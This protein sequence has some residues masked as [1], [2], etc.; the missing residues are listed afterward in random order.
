MWVGKYPPSA[1]WQR[2]IPEKIVSIPTPKSKES[3]M[4]REAV[5][6]A[7]KAHVYQCDCGLVKDVADG[8][9]SDLRLAL[10]AHTEAAFKEKNRWI[11]RV[12]TKCGY[13]AVDQDTK[14]TFDDLGAQLVAAEGELQ[15]H[16]RSLAELG[17]WECGHVCE[18][19]GDEPDECR[20]CST[21]RER[22]ALKAASEQ[23]R[24]A[25]EDIA[26]RTDGPSF[27]LGSDIR[28]IVNTALAA[29]PGVG[30]ARDEMKIWLLWIGY[31][32]LDLWDRIWNYGG[33]ER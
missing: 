1:G 12:C 17:K 23:A 11:Q 6:A 4:D 32:L 22:D 9:C 24:Q 21:Q 31:W 5:E 25:L 26:M 14:V 18:G 2:L 19:T 13:I 20:I 29:S 16:Q 28:G 33:S 10:A 27:H 15:F 30:T 3:S 7:R 8:R